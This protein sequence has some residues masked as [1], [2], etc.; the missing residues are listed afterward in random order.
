MQSSC[1]VPCFTSQLF[2]S[3]SVV[4]GL[5]ISCSDLAATV[6]TL[7]YSYSLI[8]SLYFV[9]VGDICPGVSSAVRVPGP[10]PQPVLP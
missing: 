9:A 10:K 7:S 5:F 1:T 3:G 6:H 2:R 8:V 4:F